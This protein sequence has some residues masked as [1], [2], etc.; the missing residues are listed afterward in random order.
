MLDW[1][2]VVSACCAF[3]AWIERRV[4]RRRLHRFV[5]VELERLVFVEQDVLGVRLADA[6]DDSFVGHVPL[7]L[8]AVD[9]DV[10]RQLGDRLLERVEP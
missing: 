7:R 10:G 2:S 8:C 9:L 1:A 3:F 6:L 4:G 5:L